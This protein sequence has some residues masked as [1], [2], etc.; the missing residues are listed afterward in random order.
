MT[1]IRRMTSAYYTLSC[2]LKKLK[3]ILIRFFLYRIDIYNILIKR[4]DLAFSIIFSVYTFDKGTSRKLS[5]TLSCSVQII[6][7]NFAIMIYKIFD[8][9]NFLGKNVLLL[10][11]IH[12]RLIFDI[13]GV[14]YIFKIKWLK[15]VS[16]SFIKFTH[17]FHPETRKK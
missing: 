17:K 8:N 6:I 3:R 11:F 16:F 4:Y 5:R 15:N 1:L 14:Q 9:V 2:I 12:K 10:L 13:L 7:R